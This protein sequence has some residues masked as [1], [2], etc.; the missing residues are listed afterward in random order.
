[1]VKNAV[2]A[3]VE[4]AV[5]RRMDVW[6]V[7]V[8]SRALRMSGFGSGFNRCG[9]GFYDI[10]GMTITKTRGVFNINKPDEILVD[11]T[12]YS[13]QMYTGAGVNWFLTRE[14]A[15]EG[16]EIMRRSKTREL[17]RDIARIQNQIDVMAKCDLKALAQK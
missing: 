9:E 12:G 10:D 17:E 11:D 3:A 7:G 1:M 16:A 8:T 2:D 6:V 4:A 13:S 5:P 14:A 15:I